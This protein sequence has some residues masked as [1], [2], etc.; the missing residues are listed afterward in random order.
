[1]I[2][3]S[4]ILKN[5]RALERKGDWEGAAE[6][7]KKLQS[8]DPCPPIAYNLLGDL[9]HRKQ[10]REEAYVWYQQAVERYAQ[11]GLYGNA[12]GVC[13]K[14]LR[15][16]PDRVDAFEQL[17]GLFFSQGLAREAVKHYLDFATHMLRRGD[18][19]A[20]RRT[21]DRVREVLP[22]DSSVREKLA[23]LHLSLSLPGEALED[24]RAAYAAH[25]GNGSTGEAE[26]IA[27][28][29]RELEGDVPSPSEMSGREEDAVPPV[30]VE[31]EESEA[32]PIEEESLQGYYPAE[33]TP[34]DGEADVGPFT[35]P[36]LED[37]LAGEPSGPPEEERD[38]GGGKEDAG[39]PRAA[40]EDDF[41]PVDEILREFQDGVE[42][43]LDEKDYQSHYDMGMSFKEMGLYEEALSEFEHV[44]RSPAHRGA[45]EEMR[46]AILLELGRAGEAVLVLKGLIES[47]EGD[48]LGVHYL[49]GR[50]YEELGDHPNALEEY[51][52]VEKREPS[53]QQVQERIAKVRK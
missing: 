53:F 42:K 22:S 15:Q 36:P 26:R 2:S 30:E 29:I 46:A 35:V 50:A 39:I 47:G 23:E 1:L 12:I 11:E 18:T 33:E 45:S 48:S 25:Q 3:V 19:E 27:A 44:S 37:M 51:R 5:A 4:E 21:A 10:D 8:L 32:P 41:V 38:T 40:E 49:L 31:R 20:V 7:Y 43:I 9:H 24:L 52:H 13:R 17:G 6:E 14:I 16:D 34:R 28:K